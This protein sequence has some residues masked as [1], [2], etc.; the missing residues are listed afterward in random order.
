MDE[1]W[2]TSCFRELRDTDKVDTEQGA[3]V[4]CHQLTSKPPHSKHPHCVKAQAWELGCY[5]C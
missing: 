4:M 2:T 1:K 3:D 5:Q